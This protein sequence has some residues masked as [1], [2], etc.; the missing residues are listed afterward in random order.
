MSGSSQIERPFP[1][2]TAT[3]WHA[4]SPADRRYNCIAWA[5]EDTEAW[6]EPVI[7]PAGQF[8]GGYFW[9][10][11]VGVRMT[12]ANYINLFRMRGFEICE[13]AEFEAGWSKVAL[14]SYDRGKPTHASRQLRSGA[15]TSKLGA[16]EDIEHATLDGLVGAE[17]GKVAVILRRPA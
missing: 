13:T 14:F 2:L 1:N 16:L 17:Y 4:T 15:W 12:L 3:A 5:A 9:P 8:L 10:H 11:G 6:W 7:S